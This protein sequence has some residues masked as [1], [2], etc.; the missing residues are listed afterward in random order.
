MAI[1]VNTVYTTVLSILNKEQR[2]YMTPAEFNTVG[3]QVQLQ[4]FEKYFEDLNQQLRVPQTDVNYGDRV[5]NVDEKIAIFKTFGNAVYPSGKIAGAFSLPAIDAYTNTV[6]FYRLGEVSYKNEVL[7]QKLQRNDFYSSEKSKLTKATE[8]FPTYL[9]ENELLFV[10]PT[11]ITSDIQV[12]YVRKPLPPVWGFIVGSLGQYEYDSRDF[13]AGAAGT[14][15]TG[16]RNF[17]LHISEQVDVILRILAYA[18]IIIRDP[19]IVQAAVQ[20]VQ[21]DEINSKS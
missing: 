20:Q 18:G 15:D 6:E 12:E 5:D 4:I 7:V 3:T 16:S 11:S 1:N 17:E 21:S 8:T 2:G 13:V 9:Y 19:Q 10:R 14:A